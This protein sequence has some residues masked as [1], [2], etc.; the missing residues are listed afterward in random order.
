MKNSV[1]R[2]ETRCSLVNRYN[3][4]G[5]SSIQICQTIRRHIHCFLDVIS[6]MQQPGPKRSLAGFGF[7]K[8]K[9]LQDV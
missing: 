9:H 2:G 8:S 4:F 1:C 7:L 3:L 6:H 5:E